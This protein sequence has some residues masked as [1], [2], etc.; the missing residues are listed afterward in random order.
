MTIL[1]IGASG[2]TGQLVVKQL[3]SNGEH[4]LA[5]VRNKSALLAMLGEQYIKHSLLTIIEEQVYAL[6]QQK[7]LRYIENCDA[8]ISC[9]GHNL[10]LKGIYGKPRNLVT[11]VIKNI[12]D[13]ILAVQTQSERKIKIV[14]MGTT[15]FQNKADNERVSFRHTAVVSLLRLLLPPHVDNEQAALYLLKQKKARPTLDWTIVRPDNLVNHE[16]TSKFDTY[17]APTRCAIFNAGQTSR[18]NV[19]SF[20]MRLV[21]EPRLWRTWRQQMPVIYNA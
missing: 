12:A 2:A 1:V 7:L 21:T 15:G 10:T 11:K 8:V 19:A 5:M 9:L 4:V 13:A 3:I 16:E 20:M 17:K 14:L 18:I 6:S